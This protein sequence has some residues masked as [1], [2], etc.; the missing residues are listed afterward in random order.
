MSGASGGVKERGGRKE[1]GGEARGKERG[2]RRGGKVGGGEEG[3]TGR[4]GKK[5][6][7]ENA[8]VRLPTDSRTSPLRGVKKPRFNG[9]A[10][11]RGTCTCHTFI[12]MHT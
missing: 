3:G 5:T 12:Y 10:L 11:P 8:E 9:T 7:G 1:G 2:G 6:E 4:K